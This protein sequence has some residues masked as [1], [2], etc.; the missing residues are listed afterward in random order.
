MN[1]IKLILG[2]KFLNIHL[3]IFLFSVVY[4]MKLNS[5]ISVALKRAEVIELFNIRIRTKYVLD[6]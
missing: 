2:K 1:L 5:N 6:A 4:F 3:P